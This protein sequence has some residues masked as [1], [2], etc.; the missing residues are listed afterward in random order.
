MKG[1]KGRFALVMMLTL[2]LVP[3]TASANIV[4]PTIYI[5]EGL[6]AWYVILAG[7][8]IEFL[9]IKYFIKSTWIKSG[10]MAVIMNAVSTIVGVL[11]IPF[12]GFFGAIG[13]E[14]LDSIIPVFGTFDTAQ[15]IWGYI[16]A[17]L[18]NVLVEGLTLKFIFKLKFKKMFWWLTLANA[19][20]VIIC[21]LVQGF[22]LRGIIM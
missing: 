16:L 22:F 20:S 18:S 2:M 7:L 11:L 21:I 5:A 19:I 17:V 3:T 4:W 14:L 8:I 15:W 12:V 6:R 9:A 1:E 10:L 13:L